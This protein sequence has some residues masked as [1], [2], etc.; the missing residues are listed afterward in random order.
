MHQL[1]ESWQQLTGNA[2]PNRIRDAEIT[3][4]QNFGAAAHT[5]VT[6]ILAGEA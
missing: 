3:M 6:H 2:A 5:V 4:V 1:V